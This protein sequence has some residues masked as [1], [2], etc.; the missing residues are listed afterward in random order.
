MHL[1]IKSLFGSQTSSSNTWLSEAKSSLF[2]YFSIEI[3]KNDKQHNEDSTRGII[4]HEVAAL[5]R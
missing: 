2:G 3:K 4:V 1:P 5:E